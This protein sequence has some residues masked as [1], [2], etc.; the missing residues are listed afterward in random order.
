MKLDINLGNEHILKHFPNFEYWNCTEPERLDFFKPNLVGDQQRA[1]ILYHIIKEVEKNGEVGLNLGCGQIIDPFTLGIDKFCT[2]NH[3]IYG[4]RYWPHLTADCEKLPFND[5]V[6][7]FLVGMHIFEHMERPLETFKEWIRILKPNGALILVMPD[8]NYE[9]KEHPWDI[10]HKIFYTP[11]MFKDLILEPC[12]DL[13]KTEV[14]NS[15][16]NNFS[17]NFVGRKI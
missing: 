11:E 15:L 17:F 9:D 6:F 5:S 2:D 14:F 4:G 1:F 8:A 16:G 10:D 3:P 7:S 12:K 13:M